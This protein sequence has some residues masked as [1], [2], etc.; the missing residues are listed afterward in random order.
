MK[1]FTVQ[2]QRPLPDEVIFNLSESEQDK[3][4]NNRYWLKF[5][6]GYTNQNSFDRIVGIRSIKKVKT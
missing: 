6:P 5:P 2:A 1:S 3:G 4:I